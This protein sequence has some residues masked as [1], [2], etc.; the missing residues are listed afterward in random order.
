MTTLKELNKLAEQQ[1][2][3]ADLEVAYKPDSALWHVIPNIKDYN[4]ELLWNIRIKRPPIPEGYKWCG[5]DVPAK[6]ICDVFKDKI[7][8]NLHELQ[9]LI[10]MDY[11]NGYRHLYR[12]ADNKKDWISDLDDAKEEVR[13]RKA[14]LQ[15]AEQGLEK[16]IYRYIKKFGKDEYI[17]PNIMP[18]TIDTFDDK[19]IRARLKNNNA[20]YLIDELTNDGIYVL[21]TPITWKEALEQLK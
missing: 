20:L 6:E 14:L 16:S 10:N 9:T 11:N 1:D 7:S 19:F 17:K 21:I 4:I 8:C 15:Y 3:G 18:Y 2:N 5:Y 12:R 13:S